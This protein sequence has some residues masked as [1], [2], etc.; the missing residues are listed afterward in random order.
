MDQKIFRDYDL[1]KARILKKCGYEE[2]ARSLLSQICA[3]NLVS[4]SDCNVSSELPHKARLVLAEFDMEAC[5]PDLA[6]V[7]L[8]KVS[9]CQS[10]H[11]IEKI[12]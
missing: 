12:F 7:E 1:T 2:A 8:R 4:A 11:R 10:R 5:R 6:E 3:T 9:A